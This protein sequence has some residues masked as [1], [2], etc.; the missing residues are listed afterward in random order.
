MAEGEGGDGFAERFAKDEA[1]NGGGEVDPPPGPEQGQG[2]FDQW[3]AEADG[4]VAAAAAA[5]EEDPAEQGDVF[6]PGQGVGA[7]AAV[8]AGVGEAFVFGKAAD[9]D[10]EEAAEAEAGEGGEDGSEI[11]GG[12]DFAA[13]IFCRI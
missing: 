2:E 6:E 8:G 7:V 11:G 4:G 9:D 13:S 1:G 10:V 12:E 3:V 5:A